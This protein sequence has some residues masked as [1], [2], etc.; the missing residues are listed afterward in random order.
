ML[1]LPYTADREAAYPE[2]PAGHE[3]RN[4]SIWQGGSVGWWAGGDVFCQLLRCEFRA[5]LEPPGDA[6]LFVFP[7]AICGRCAGLARRPDRD[8]AVGASSG[9]D[10]RVADGADL[11]KRREAE[12]IGLVAYLREQAVSSLR[13]SNRSFS[14]PESAG[15]DG[16]FGVGKAHIGG[17]VVLPAV[18]D[19]LTRK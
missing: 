16:H 4:L 7:G 14:G 2:P 12:V 3:S 9:L 17:L 13:S 6:D 10:E 11:G 19:R 15:P 5:I 18:L 1:H 8:I